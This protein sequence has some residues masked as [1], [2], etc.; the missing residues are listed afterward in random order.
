[1]QIMLIAFQ[2]SDLVEMKKYIEKCVALLEE[3]GDWERKNKLKVY[4]GVYFIMVRDFKSAAE[5]LLDCM[6]TF[7]A[8]E[9]VDFDTLIFYT[10]LASMMTLERGD[11]KK[12]VMKNSEVLSVIKDNVPLNNF[13]NAYYTCDYSQFFRVMID[14]V[15][16]VET[17]RI[18]S[19]HR[20]FIIKEL[21]IMIYTQFLESY[22]NVTLDHMAKAFGVSV[23][24]LDKELSDFISARRLHCKI[25]KVRNI[26][27][28][29]KIDH[30]TTDYKRAIR[31]GEVILNRI[32]RLS[33]VIDV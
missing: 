29:E 26:I 13:L 5:K 3:G 32:Q 2:A 16:D 28:Y 33:R 8:P 4:E 22:K 30:R 31:E 25:D 21:R 20:K 6:S 15:K 17:D 12:K 10:V 9:V 23:K 19:S 24:F 11:I 14:V 18:M 27:E 7:N 1:M